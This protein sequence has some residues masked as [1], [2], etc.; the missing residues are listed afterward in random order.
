MGNPMN[1]S[2]T[3]EDIEEVFQRKSNLLL[4]SLLVVRLILAL[5]NYK[6]LN[7]KKESDGGCDDQFHDDWFRRAGSSV[8]PVLEGRDC[9]NPRRTTNN[10]NNSTPR[11]L[12]QSCEIFT[13]SPYVTIGT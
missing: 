8:L 7:K 9:V 10:R 6:I 2:L 12:C 11:L 5:K 13:S 1:S 4:S 3:P